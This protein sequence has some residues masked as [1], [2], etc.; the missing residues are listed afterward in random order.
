MPTLSMDFF[1][2]RSMH[3]VADFSDKRGLV[4]LSGH[5]GKH[6]ADRAA[7]ILLK[8][9]HAVC[10]RSACRKINQQLAKRNNIV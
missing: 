2:K 7:G 10:G 4:P 3:I 1:Q 6:V 9:T 5:R 8:Q